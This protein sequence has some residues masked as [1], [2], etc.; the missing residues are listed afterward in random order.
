MADKNK[1]WQ[2]APWSVGEKG[3]LKVS[4]PARNSSSQPGPS[5]SNQGPFVNPYNFVSVEQ[6]ES[7]C[8]RQPFIHGHEAFSDGCFSGR[9]ECAIKLIT[10]L[11][12][13]DPQATV[14]STGDNPKQMSFIRDSQGRPM[15]PASSLK[16]MVR[17]ML[18]A[19]SN[20]CFSQIND[21]RLDYRDTDVSKNL[22]PA[23]IVSLDEH[24]KTAG[25]VT[26]DDM[27]W[28]PAGYKG[29]S[30]Y[31]NSLHKIKSPLRFAFANLKKVPARPK[32]NHVVPSHWVVTSSLQEDLSKLPTPGPGEI[33]RQVLIKHTG[34]AIRNK[35]DERVFF[36]DKFP[37]DLEK[38]LV[39]K[40][41]ENVPFNAIRDF[42]YI[43]S[44][45][46]E[47]F[48]KQENENQAAQEMEKRLNRKGPVRARLHDLVY[49]YTPDQ[50][51]ALVLIPRLRYK[52]S[53]ADLLPKQLKPCSDIN[54]LCPACRIFGTVSEVGTA[55]Q[56]KVSFSSG[57]I[58][59][60]NPRL[61]NG[62]LL[63]ILGSPQPT[64]T[65][66]YVRD[67]EDGNLPVTP[68]EGGYDRPYT[69]LRGRKFYWVSGHGYRFNEASKFNSRVELLHPKAADS[70]N[71][72]FSFSVDFE[73]LTAGEL[74]LLLWSIELE[75]DMYQRLGMGKPLGLGL[76]KTTVDRDKS[77]AIDHE[78]ISAYYRDLGRRAEEIGRRKDE[79][80]ASWKQTTIQRFSGSSN[81]KD[82]KTIASLNPA[83]FEQVK[84]P[85]SSREIDGALQ[86]PG[87]QWFS[88]NKKQPLLTIEQISAGERQTGWKGETK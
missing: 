64:A 12:I 69:M 5:G 27:A 54:K 83:I 56:G 52:K 86:F 59:T 35:H 29:G 9:L 38:N 57:T 85:Q 74:G 18:E 49:F 3:G 6:N 39:K 55:V 41:P 88:E 50:S 22:K 33:Q 79:E 75:A 78:G 84:Y 23:V 17:S 58:G 19:I 46:K 60:S 36:S 70:N 2:K 32:G 31:R 21:S 87:F 1:K 4:S 20:S 10:P 71:V 11:F 34:R 45:Q 26:L 37:L 76:I 42:N 25:V 51:I 53:P 15:I 63:K 14:P 40:K 81:Y 47:R 28:L 61:E 73:N 67:Q 77:F 80:W 82:L 43:L 66:F 16:G 68:K 62:V 65:C 13:P 8:D 7:F 30:D 24:K 44:E 72:S 48:T